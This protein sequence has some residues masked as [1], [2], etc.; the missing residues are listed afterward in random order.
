M[1]IETKNGGWE[2]TCVHETV[3]ELASTAELKN[4]HG[5]YTGAFQAFARRGNNVFDLHEIVAV[6][7]P[8]LKQNL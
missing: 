7:M 1:E 3:K 8:T 4:K 5:A 2:Q 6:K